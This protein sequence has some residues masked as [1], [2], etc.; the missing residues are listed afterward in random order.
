M[1][2]ASAFLVLTAAAGVLGFGRAESGKS[3]ADIY[4][5]G[6]VRFVQEAALDEKT[7]PEGVMFVG[8]TDVT[9][10]ADGR[11][12]VLDFSDNNLKILMPPGS[13]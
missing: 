12:F 2:T 8:P 9:V 11:V 4:R 13:F 1:K 3:L 5:S 7:M 10:G 6:K